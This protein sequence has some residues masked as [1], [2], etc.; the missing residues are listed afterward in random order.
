MSPFADRLKL[1]IGD[2]LK[3][4]PELN[5]PPLDIVYIDAE[6]RKYREYLDMIVPMVKSGGFILAD[7][8]LWYGQVLLEKKSLDTQYI[9]GFTKYCHQHPDLETLFLPVFDGILLIR[10]K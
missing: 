4:I 8:V 6:K 7:N 3:L 10:K 2:A 9:D 5:L 1:H